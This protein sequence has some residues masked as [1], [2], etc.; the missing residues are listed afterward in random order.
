MQTAKFMFENNFLEK[1]SDLENSNLRHYY[2]LIFNFFQK[3][4]SSE[5]LI[6][7]VCK[8]VGIDE[9]IYFGLKYAYPKDDKVPK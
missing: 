2:S 1:K 7:E 6:N 9:R 4:K 5:D 3:L 8:S